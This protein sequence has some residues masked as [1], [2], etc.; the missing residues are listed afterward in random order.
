MSL[1]LLNRTTFRELVF[2]RDKH[3]CVTCGAPGQD[4]HHIMERRLFPDGGYYLDNGA[5]LC[6]RCH[7]RAEAT[8]ISCEAIREA[9]GIKEVVLPPHLYKDDRYD[10]W[11]NVILENGQ[12]LKGELF[13]D[14][15]VQKILADDLHRFTNRVKYPRTFHLPWS[16]GATDDDRVME[17]LSGLEGKEVVVTVKMDGEH[18]TLYK[19]GL[20]ARSIDYTPHPSRNWLRNM[21]AKIAHEIPDGFRICGENLYAKHSIEYR[22]LSSYFMAYGVWNGNICASWDETEEWAKLLDLHTVPVLYR[23]P[24]DPKE[25]KGLVAEHYKGDELEGY[26]VRIADQFHASEFR[27]VV[28]K[29]V[30]AEHVRT[31]GHW[32]RSKLEVN[33]VIQ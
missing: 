5:T 1:Q 11:G 17:D 13:D 32:M 29:Y 27:R 10:K 31:H 20:H 19:D 15:S 26:V 23:G 24:F 21:H 8:E 3:K 22:A 30:R 18:A 4:A 28:G 14:E 2:A 12:R 16:P 33:G 6:G 25:V 7:L 9:A